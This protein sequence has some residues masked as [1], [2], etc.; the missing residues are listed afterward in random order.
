MQ[1]RLA[2]AFL[3]AAG[4][5]LSVA[6]SV[7]ATLYWDGGTQDLF[8]NG[9]GLSAGGAGTWNSTLLNWDAGLD[10]PE[11]ALT[12][13][14]DASFGGTGGVVELGSNVSANSVTFAST[15][16]TLTGGAGSYALTLGAGG[17]TANY[18]S[19][20]DAA[21][22]LGAAQTWTVDTGATVTQNGALS[23]ANLLTKAGA[24]TLALTAA[25]GSTGGFTINAG[26]LQFAT[27]ALGASGSIT[28]GGGTLKWAASNTS[29]ISSRLVFTSGQTATLDTGANN[30]TFASA[31][32][33][34]SSAAVVKSGTGTLTLNAAN[35]FSGGIT[36]GAGTV[37]LGNV[38]GLGSGAATV[39][40]GATLDLAGFGA[41]NA[42]TISGSGNGTNPALWNSAAAAVAVSNLTLADSASIANTGNGSGDVANSMTLNAVNL[43]GK[44]LTI[45]SGVVSVGI[46]L[47]TSGDIVIANGGVLYS[48]N[49]G[50]LT[51]VTGTITINTGGKMQTRDLDNTA[52]TTAHTIY[53]NGGQLGR[54]TMTGN[55]GGGGGTVLMNNITVDATNGGSIVN[56]NGSFGMNYRLQGSLSGSGALTL[57]GSR[58]VEWRGDMIN[59]TGTMTSS[60]GNLW[61]VPYATTQTFAGTLAGTTGFYKQ[62]TNTT[63]FT[64]TTTM[65]GATRI[66]AGTLRF[67]YSTNNTQKGT[68]GALTLGAN[69]SPT[70][71]LVGGSGYTETFTGTTLTNASTTTLSRSSGSNS[72]NLGTVTTNNGAINLLNEGFVKVSN[73][74]DGFGYLGVWATFGTSAQL[75]TKDVNG[76]I[77]AATPTADIA[78]LGS[79][80]QI[81]SSTSTANLRLVEGTGSTA[82]FT[83][84]STTNAIN[85]LAQ[86]A[87]GGSSAATIDLAN[88]ALGINYILVGTGAGALTIGASANSGIIKST[89]T[90]LSIR[91]QAGA[92][93]TINSAI[94]NGTGASSLTKLDV[95]TLTLTAQN[96]Y[97]GGTTVGAG[98]LAL[99][100][101]G[102]LGAGVYTGTIAITNGG[103][104]FASTAQQ[105]LGGVISGS[106][107][108]TKSTGTG[109]LVLTGANT[110][111]G[112]TTI[113]T[114]TLQ[115]GDTTSTASTLGSNSNAAIASGA[116]LVF[117]RGTGAYTYGGV[118]SGAGNVRFLGNGGASAGD[119]ALSGTMTMT[120]SMT[121]TGARLIVDA[122]ADV[123]T[124]SGITVN[125]GG[126]VYVSAAIAF[127]KALTLSGYGWNESA[128][129]LGAVRLDSTSSLTSTVSLAANARIG[130]WSS[131][132]NTVSGVISGAG[133][134]DVFSQ[135]NTKVLTISAANTYTGITTVNQ[136]KLLATNTLQSTS[137]VYIGSTGIAEFQGVNTFTALTAAVGYNRSLTADG[138]QIILGAAAG[139][140]LGNLSILNGGTI[141][142]NQTVAGTADWALADTGMGSAIVTVANVSGNTTAATL[143]SGVASSGIHLNS[144]V[145]FSVADVT[146]STASDLNVNL[147]LANYASGIN[148]TAGALLKRGAGTMTLNAA[149][150][151]AGT[152]TIINGAIALSTASGAIAS[153]ATLSLS[154]GSTLLLNNTAAANNTNRLSNTAAVNLNGATLNFAN[155]AGASTNFSETTGV[156]TIGGGQ[157]N[158]T[159][160]QAATGQT[161]TLTFASL[162]RTSGAVNFAINGGTAITGTA[163]TRANI[164]LTTP[165]T[166]ANGI[167]GAWATVNQA[168]WATMSASGG[169]VVAYTGYT[170]AAAAGSTITGT[171][172]TNIRVTGAGTTGAISL[173]TTTAL[174]TLLMAEGTTAATLATATKTLSI[175]GIYAGTGK[176]ALTI[177]AAAGDGLLQAASS[178]GTLMIGSD[179]TNGITVNAV[180][181][182]NTSASGLLKYGTGLVTL[183]GT[184]TYSGA[185]NLMAGTLKAT[186][187]SALGSGSLT[188]AGGTLQLAT[189]TAVGSRAV[190]LAGNAS[191]VLDRATA[192]AGYTTTFST[193]TFNESY[194]L[195][196]SKGA[197]VT[198]G[199]ANL[200]F[201]G[202]V[203]LG[204]TQGRIA[205]FNIG[206]GTEVSL[207]AGNTSTG[208]YA[209]IDK[210]G[211]GTL[212]MSGS[213]TY[214]DPAGNSGRIA[215]NGG[216]LDLRG[217]T[218]L[219]DGT[220]SANSIGVALAA[221]TTVKI[222]TDTALGNYPWIQATG[223][224][225]TVTL[226]RSTAGAGIT[227]TFQG[228]DVR[229]AY[230]VNFTAGA[231]ITSGTNQ[232]NFTTGTLWGNTTLNI[233]NPTVGSNVVNFSS[234]ISDVMG[235]RSL[236]KT[237]TG[238]LQLSS[239]NTF[240]GGLVLSAGQLNINNASALGP[241]VNKLTINGGTLDNTSGSAITVA[242][243]N[244]QT[245]GGAF[246][247]TGT[248]ALNL[249]N[250]VVTLSANS[251]VTV[252]ASTLT[253]GGQ[254]Y[255]AFS[256]TKAGAGTLTLSGGSGLQSTYSGG[257]TLSAGTLNLN[258][259]TAAG[260][261]AGTFTIQG[262][263]LNN[264]SGVAVTL[265]NNNAQSWAGDFAFTGTNALN[266]GTGAVTLTSSRGLQVN[267]GVLTVGGIISGSGFS[268]TKAGAGTLVLNGA[269]T[270]SGGITVA[271]GTLVAGATSA[272]N[273]KG[274]LNG[275]NLL[276]AQGVALSV[277]N[278]LTFA[279][280]TAATVA[281]QGGLASIYAFDVNSA[282]LIVNT[283]I[284]GS[285]ANSVN[286]G[287]GTYGIRFDVNGTGTLTVA[288]VIN[289][290]G[291]VGG[292][293]VN[294][295]T[296]VGT[297]TT[298]LFKLGDGDLTLTGASTFTAGSNVA[299]T[300]VQAGR[301]I[302]SGGNNRLPSNSAVYLGSSTN[303]SGKLVLGGISQSITGL[304]TIGNGTGNAVVG[305]SGVLS[306]LAVTNANNYTFAGT[307]GGTGTNENNLAFVK[308][309]A[310]TLTLTGTNTLLGGTTI[311]AGT[312][313]IGAGGTTGL[314]SGAVTNNA[315]I[316]FNRSDDSEF[317]SVISGTGTLS[318]QGDGTLTLSG[319]NNYSGVT[320]ISGGTIAVTNDTNLGSAPGSAA[321]AQLVLNGGTLS[322]TAGFTL[323]VNRGISLGASGGTIQVATGQTLAYGGI[324]AGGALTKTGNG[325]LSLSGVNTYSGATS[326]SA[327]TLQLGSSASISG[328]AVSVA[329]GAMLSGAGSAGATTIDSGGSLTAGLSGVGALTL[330]SLTFSGN[331]TVNLAASGTGLGSYLTVNGDVVAS[332]AAGSV[333]FALGS[334]LASL[335][336]G[337]YSLLQY[338]G[339]ELADISAFAWSG[340]KGGRQTVSLYHLTDASSGYRAVQLDILNAFPVWVGAAGGGTWGY[341]DTSWK[342]NTDDSVTDFRSTDTVVFR[343]DAATGSIE[344]TAD[345][346]PSSITFSG[347]V[348][349]Y[350]IGSTGSFKI[351]S[352][353]LLKSGN[354][355]L[356]LT[357]A[358]SFA[359]GTRLS[360]G[361]LRIGN[362]EALGSGTIELAGGKLTSDGSSARSL[363]NAV[364]ISGNVTL[365]DA[366]D[367]GALALSGLVDLGG[368]T[369]T[370]T[371]DSATT[372]S[373]AI[374]NGGLTK[375]GN[376]TL[377]LAGANAYGDGT[378]VS[379][380][381]LQVGAGATSG[382]LTGNVS[383]A[384]AATLAFNRS[385]NL[386]YA[387]VISGQGSLT[388]LGNGTLSLTG[389]NVQSGGT[390][391]SAG[392]LQLGI[393]GIVGSLEG[394][395]SVANGATLAFN[396]SDNV[397]YAGTVTGEGSLT[398]LGSGALTLTGS[399][400]FSGGVTLSAGTLRIGNTAALG[401]GTLRA[402]AGTISSDST[403]ARSIANNVV[404]GGNLTF[405]DL[406]NTGALTVSGTVDLD[407]GTRQLTLI[408]DVTLTGSISNGALTKL[409]TAALTLSGDNNFAGGVTL[410]A[411]TLN[412]ASATALGATA[413][414]FTINGATLNNTSGS[415]L[416]LTTNN[417]QSWAGNFTFTGTNSLDLGTGGVALTAA[418]TVTVSDNTLTV[419]GNITG[420]Y[421]LT[422]AGA[423]TLTLNGSVA[424][425]IVVSAGSLTASGAIGGAFT[426]SAGT[427][428]LT[429]T[430]SV[431]GLT[432]VTTGTLNAAGSLNGGVAVNGGTLT[433]TGS[434]AGGGSVASGVLLDSSGAIAGNI[435]NAGTLRF[436]GDTSRTY[437]GNLTGAGALVKTGN[438]NLTLTG[439][440]AAGSLALQGGTVTLSNANALGSIPVTFSSGTTLA[441]TLNATI[442][443][444]LTFSGAATVD[445]A[446]G[447]TLTASG[448]WALSNTLTKTGDGTLKL[449]TGYYT[450][451]TSTAAS[452]FIVNAG[453]LE[454]STGSWT[455]NAFSGNNTL[456]ITVN[457]GATLR[458]SA[459]HAF[460]GSNLYNAINVITVV[461]GTLTVDGGF[462]LSNGTVSSRG[463]LVLDGATVNGAAEINACNGGGGTSYV[464]TL[465]NAVT[466]TISNTNGLS[467]GYGNFSLDVADG[468]AAIDLLVSTKIIGGGTIAK[469][470]AGFAQFTG[471]NTYSG[472]TTLSAGTLSISSVADVGGNGSIGTGALTI[473]G[474][475]LQ[476]T[477]T[478]AQNTTRA[479]SVTGAATFDVTSATGELTFASTNGIAKSLTKNGNGRLNL[480]NAI[481]G[482]TSSITVNGGTLALSGANT[483]GGG[484]SVTA[485][486]L[487]ATAAGTLGTA[488][489]NVS[490]GTLDFGGFAFNNAINF[491]GG[492]LTNATGLTGAIEIAGGTLT[493]GTLG[494]YGA[495]AITVSAGGTFDL[496]FLNPTGTINLS[497]GALINAG[498]WN[499]GSVN[500]S[501][502][503]TA[504]QINA[505]AVT[506]VTISTGSI[507]LS[508]VTRNITLAGGTVSG[509]GG[510]TGSLTV[511]T[512][513]VDLSA[514][515]PASN[516]SIL[517][518]GG[519]VNFGTRTSNLGINYSAGAISGVNYT[520]TLTV[521]GTN[522]ALGSGIAAGTVAVGEGTS[523]SI[524]A[525]FNRDLLY[526]GGTL[527]GF[528][529]YTG[530]VT[531][532]G[533][534]LNLGTAASPLTSTANV[535]LAAGGQLSGQGT[536]GDVVVESGA[537]LAPGNSPGLITVD[538]LT[539]NAGAIGQF[540]I[541]SITGDELAGGI[542]GGI[543]Y[544]S[545]AVAGTLDLS[546]LSDV[547][548]F[549]IHLISLAS[550]DVLG[551]I[552]DW[553]SSTMAYTFKIFTY[554]ELYLGNNETMRLGDVTNLFNINSTQFV[555]EYGNVIKAEHFTFADTGTSIQ[556][557]YSVVPEPSTY[558]L[559][560]GG[561][562]LAMA[563]VRRRR[564]KVNP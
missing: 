125:Q 17:L 448:S 288:G 7:G 164:V 126:T 393:G 223:D 10:L 500:I 391:V 468:A 449:A 321:A 345:V 43:N 329:S 351:T 520:G 539:L 438:G 151:Y 318:K 286:V 377:T 272:I 274:T 119:Y 116:A 262:G 167:I 459:S 440:N 163:N 206:A 503:Y 473:T 308:S 319:L 504:A 344:I 182:N 416:A 390:T 219:G 29:D 280:N 34:S 120:G 360:A 74:V 212:I 13:V 88:R 388:K 216:T 341:S 525:G 233:S 295:G 42:I 259:P 123:A 55:N 27:G 103:L 85:S 330:S 208:V 425:N 353:S 154:G 250:G 68:A 356:T 76:Y 367:N 138:G 560:L 230:T 235:P 191:I 78:R 529:N 396:R 128:G 105:L 397:T 399:S 200:T 326:I 442:S 536:L 162:A 1:K 241:M 498:N 46:R 446:N 50:S 389:A 129:Y 383:V 248:N 357:S 371:V 378:T 410:T 470:G 281:A 359:G 193:L 139:G 283:G 106:G 86:S 112:A 306:T 70:I 492:A 316:V 45:A 80:T 287:T 186:N 77:V 457:S 113:S 301:L 264:T 141:T 91:D 222:S 555:D 421:A 320:T 464:T 507:S 244:I 136:A 221:A 150:T 346:D 213:Y 452:D 444:T 474:G 402:N 349:A 166:T 25:T 299:S 225:A 428:T 361:T 478:T 90:A 534:T 524:Q 198:S 270:F 256:L 533:T 202:L 364:L 252:N 18:S 511:N 278:G 185:L 134:L 564:L 94:A 486:T 21:V 376:A 47:L 291:N 121:L 401:A 322:A 342:L 300:S 382:S 269:N 518:L 149:N 243:D 224:G 6:K 62:G 137:A 482:A 117:Y 140:L 537:V 407:A 496:N 414:T 157:N 53:L 423:G 501:S 365:G 422:K 445:V 279:S 174:N 19:Q 168:D 110:Y 558:G 311:S 178:G 210:F 437:A 33:S 195:S 234:A 413:G 312:L 8:I 289:G 441:S 432:T 483:Y 79:S 32:G 142:S 260:A 49:G 205:G 354:A 41:T 211:A 22:V 176:A 556:L 12:N 266:L 527:A 177:G 179:A 488:Q 298:A 132:A 181:Q 545:I 454:F 9:D 485:G 355:S 439:S 11:V 546:D 296:L 358:N 323:N 420:A 184:N 231:N 430:S 246:A 31:I 366:T 489:I 370:L 419:G 406:V 93:I 429:S 214:W 554:T 148:T 369:R 334:G 189:D 271:G 368:A 54:A 267:G 273:G 543:D 48:Q 436:S 159:I 247:F 285:I 242:N 363:T 490:G 158:I 261:T 495:G 497:G 170:D 392:T 455:G 313:Q 530:T 188:I 160:S 282:D 317:S 276:I 2:K 196:V 477:G 505:L 101:T 293:V 348:L 111:S 514:G 340:T 562:A 479:F 509:L 522:V 57:S 347:N 95:G 544:D 89:G 26:T 475:T 336:E 469:T 227:N 238:T 155:D 384:N 526:T 506:N 385:D 190:T 328:S 236:T 297:D 251:T 245:W 265:V 3:I 66:E 107:T 63:V 487:L 405:G 381:T 465:A 426:L 400:D 333:T 147:I 99:T 209:G 523:V 14:D 201:S 104:N 375:A 56:N 100:G 71:D 226:D 20:I 30:L 535:T 229:G 144:N 314:F 215:V 332:G 403:T 173:G 44:T 315:A 183:A 51:S 552:A 152:T 343:D 275:G 435:A 453:T 481:T 131:A 290:T 494:A 52:M 108:L 187:T 418:R 427:G 146:A 73:E 239:A 461:G 327:G 69:G 39:S 472:T 23:G 386:T 38:S 374:S 559:I 515:E 547:N 458:T 460:G 380:G 350:N 476:Y 512:G 40:P 65:T 255:G 199:T 456:N 521:Q 153:S 165:F 114:G 352:G 254:I 258:N 109:L 284:N 513:T 81:I 339:A 304:A 118:L 145:V 499:S 307:L 133:G 232:I 424:N 431:A 204:G 463:R 491:T 35:T 172:A 203:Q 218:V 82:N 395:V 398:K 550:A 480:G 64:G 471:N 124:T 417:A 98:T 557:T 257:L 60:A 135:N 309:G 517:L 268:I 169:S 59:Y 143:A 324:I 510:Y 433:S 292:G 16:Y 156:L 92:G 451:S 171:S 310:G 331:T 87:S 28:M 467:M 362:N 538:N 220:N 294:N 249:G 37:K 387:G 228:L 450:S 24:G 502:S 548:K 434:L 4:I 15:G 180:I 122:L 161:S 61:F 493:L 443:G 335:S 325:V 411:G 58:G 462:Y 102:Q 409:G 404:V 84:D 207:T 5:S 302:L 379:A 338:S 484:T 373:G 563:A 540:Q 237:G 130:T 67:D 516:G 408:K 127:S 303:T 528:S 75:A 561:L 83:L 394:N 542:I 532:Q 263:T 240:S 194:I 412:L 36:V 519:T 197:N 305:G 72:L 217:S 415:S 175:S 531:V 372:L 115:V 553:D 96:T 447:T 97:T 192:G 466:S 337:K 508:G 549:Q 541:Q 551:S 277:E 253:V